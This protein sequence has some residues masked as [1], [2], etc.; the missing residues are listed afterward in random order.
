MAHGIMFHHFHSADHK[1]RPGSISAEDFELMIDYLQQQFTILHPEDFFVEAAKGNTNNPYIVL[2]FDD[3][4]LSQFD[5][6]LPVL[7]S[8]GIKGIF[9][10]YSSVFTGNPDALEI[11]AA[12]RNSAFESFDEFFLVFERQVRSEVSDNF[13]VGQ[14]DYPEGY[15]A[16]F[17]FYSENERRFRFLRDEIL[18]PGPYATLMWGLIHAETHFNLEEEISSLWMETDSV[19]RIKSLGHT[20]GMHSHSHPTR[21][22]LLSRAAQ[23]EEYDKNFSWIHENL[24]LEPKVVAHPCGRYSRETLEILSGLGAKFGFRSSRTEGE[25]GTLLEIPREDHANIYRAMVSP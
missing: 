12:F 20:I 17:P 24:K 3:A 9:S 14:P 21:M 25:F 18:G 23:Q 11:F 4:L 19:R 2:T 16:D 22:D 1:R 8:R 10:V 6:A 15:L 13:G 7:E 5:I